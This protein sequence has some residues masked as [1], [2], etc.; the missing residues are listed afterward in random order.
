MIR[1]ADT[2][3]IEANDEERVLTALK[4]VEANASYESVGILL[5][6]PP[7]IVQAWCE[8]V[9]AAEAEFNIRH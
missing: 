5:G 4:L 9:W 8:A 3:I 2:D 1:R 7:A 6:V